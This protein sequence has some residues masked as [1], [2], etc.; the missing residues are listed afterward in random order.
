MNTPM[1][2]FAHYVMMSWFT[3]AGFLFFY[4]WL[5]G[6]V[7]VLFALHRISQL[8]DRRFELSA[9]L[10]THAALHYYC[11]AVYGLVL[12]AFYF[13]S[14]RFRHELAWWR[15]GEG[16]NTRWTIAL[17]AICMI[18]L[19]GR[20]AGS[21]LAGGRPRFGGWLDRVMAGAGLAL[22]LWFQL[23]TLA[24]APYSRHPFGDMTNA[25]PLLQSIVPVVWQMLYPQFF[26]LGAT[27]VY[28]LAFLEARRAP[29][30]PVSPRR[31]RAGWAL[32][33]VAVAFL[34]APFWLSIPRVTHARAL[35][36][37]E[38]HREL[39]VEVAAEAEL[40]PRL[41]AGIIYVA[42][43]RDQP[44]WTGEFIDRL[45]S[46]MDDDLVME[47]EFGATPILDASIGLV[48]M[49]RTTLLSTCAYL[50]GVQ[51][52]GVWVGW[53][54][55]YFMNKPR[56]PEA[57]EQRIGISGEFYYAIG[58]AGPKLEQPSSALAAAGAMLFL[59]REQWRQAGHPIDQRP[60]ILATL[61]NLGYKR[62]RPHG[63]P[64]AND[65]GRRVKEFMDSDAC[66]RLFPAEEVADGTR[67]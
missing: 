26:F 30:P 15:L 11:A 18:W 28:G 49:K 24:Q 61:Y 56:L 41:L 29:A 42:H 37:V 34:F 48:Q 33:A 22:T 44:R 20:L 52:S 67:D 25:P 55:L 46:A 10:P 58:E 53:E 19:A 12:P 57:I 6:P 14:V 39:I 40:D 64:R 60:E 47:P 2:A 5:N 7:L 1:T 31:R 43:R 66:R 4:G 50:E 62:S 9:T 59:L 45:S 35:A 23:L 8:R 51:G 36:L 32:A 16:V 63:S 54:D 27:L 65:F 3:L 13:L 17:G 38:D 21:L